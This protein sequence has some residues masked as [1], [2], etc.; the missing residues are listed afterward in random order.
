MTCALPTNGPRLSRSLQGT[1]GDT[2]LRRSFGRQAT[3]SGG[4][5]PAPA[6]LRKGEAGR[7]LAAAPHCADGSSVGCRN[8]LTHV[9]PHEHF[10]A[11][12]EDEMSA[13]PLVLGASRL[14]QR[15][16]VWVDENLLPRLRGLL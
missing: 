13:W 15:D 12:G 14:R 3:R 7:R 5:A 4:R 8:E 9:L 11:V 2:C 16:M 1:P 10:C 6:P